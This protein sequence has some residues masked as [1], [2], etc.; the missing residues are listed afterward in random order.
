MR[1]SFEFSVLTCLLKF[2]CA[3]NRA[4][5]ASSHHHFRSFERAL[6]PFITFN[7]LE[8]SDVMPLSYLQLTTLFR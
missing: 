1:V 6:E 7:L 3:E 2:S 5:H 8:V 4:S